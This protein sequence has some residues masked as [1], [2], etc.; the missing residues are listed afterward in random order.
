LGAADIQGIQSQGPMAQV[1]HYAD[2]N[3]ET[4]RNTA[5]DN[6][7]VSERAQREIY[8]PAFAA[9]VQQGQAYSVMCSY[10]SVGGTYACESAVLIQQVLESELGFTGFVHLRL[11]RHP[12]HGRLGQQRPGPGDERQRLLRTA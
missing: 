11:G 12:L 5:S 3:Q 1:K 10:S 8:L 7:I 6:V 9:A 2:Y 4:Y